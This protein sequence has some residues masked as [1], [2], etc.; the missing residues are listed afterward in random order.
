MTLLMSSTA[1]RLRVTLAASWWAALVGSVINVAVLTATWH[2]AYGLS[3]SMQALLSV[4]AGPWLW[5]AFVGGALV[6]AYVA[7]TLAAGQVGPTAVVALAYLVVSYRMWLLLREP[8]VLMPGTPL[9]LYLVGW[10]LLLGL[11]A[12]AGRLEGHFR[13]RS[14][15]RGAFGRV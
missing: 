12:L 13:S 1:A 5:W 7:M 10:P 9:D 3:G 14:A 4:Q 2:W 8:Y 11:A 6:G 15:G